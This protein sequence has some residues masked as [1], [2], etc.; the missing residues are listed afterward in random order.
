[1]KDIRPERL[2][3]ENTEPWDK[4]VPADLIPAIKHL[5]KSF[6]DAHWGCGQTT[7]VFCY[8]LLHNESVDDP[9][10]EYINY[11]L[12]MKARVGRAA[13]SRFSDLVKEVTLPTAFKAFFDLYLEGVSAQAL[14][15]FKELVEIGR[16]NENRLNIPHL[17][18][19]EA[20]TKHLIRSDTHHINIWVRDVCDKHVYDRNEDMEEKVFWRKWQAP[21]FLIMTPSLYT[22]YDAAAVWD[23]QDAESSSQLLQHFAEHYVVHLEVK[24]KKAAGERALELAKKPIPT[25]TGA[26]DVDLTRLNRSNSTGV[27]RQPTDEA[28]SPAKSVRR[29]ARKLGT[30][31]VH[32]SWRREYRKLKKKRP[33]MTDVWYSQ[34]IAKLATAEGRSAETI[35]KHMTT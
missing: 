33:D 16:A 26:A 32:E 15:I 5:R 30:Q 22:P 11:L 28:P 31:A 19:A 8:A 23:R 29:E 2:L 9:R 3:Y 4:D 20:Q 13:A 17:E 14:L 10:K 27:I 12:H 7:Q 35:R 24:L 25:Q 6:D 18:W 34:Q 21:L 1:M